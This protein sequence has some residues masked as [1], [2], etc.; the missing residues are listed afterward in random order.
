MARPVKYDLIKILDDAMELFWEKGF[1]NVSIVDLILHTGIN[2]STMYSLFSDKEA[3][4]KE[5]LHHYYAKR[6][7]M[8]IGILQTNT[9][10]KGVEL[11][12]GKFI[13]REEFRACLFSICMGKG[14]FMREEVFDVPKKFFLDLRQQLEKNL[15]DAS[16][17]GEFNGNAKAI[18]LTIVTIVHG[19]S[20]HGKYNHQKEDGELIIQTILALLK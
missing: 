15:M 12:L 14:D 4:F 9:G 20:I 7:S 10:K 3:L 17:N 18:A 2:R 8:M 1:E 13:F 11:F 5:A 16:A 6:A 19:F